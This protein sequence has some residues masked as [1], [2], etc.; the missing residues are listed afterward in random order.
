M[1]PDWP[2]AHGA[3]LFP[4]F[5][6][7]CSSDFIVD[8]L[9]GFEPSGDGEHDLLRIRKTDTNT[10][11]LARQMARHAGVAAK[12]VGYCGLKDRHAVTSQW[13]SVRRP[14]GK[15]TDWEAFQ[16]D[17]VELISAALHSR[18]LRPGSHA[19]NRFRIALRADSEIDGDAI[20]QRLNRIKADGV[21]NYFGEQRF[22]RDAGN[23]EIAKRLFSGARL[24][25]EQ[26]SIALSSARSFLFNEILAARVSD[27]TWNRILPGER[28]NLAG[29]G[30]VFSVEL[31][32]SE[33]QDRCERLDIHPTATLWG[34]G[35]PLSSGDVADLERRSI[36]AHAELADGLEKARV[37]PSSR[38]TRMHAAGLDWAVEQD[39]LWLEFELAPGGFATALLREIANV[40]DAAIQRS[41]SST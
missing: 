13:F 4:A 21:P 33:L 2:R 30:S 26:R 15:G 9:L 32:D 1:L 7:R 24:K 3:A 20:G 8:E 35:A 6:R 27:A 25:R 39:A 18:K 41:S 37:D 11:W 17:G 29:S 5:I 12:D 34:D 14:T 40:T 38:A 36:A 10:Q 28:A 31:V 19:A 16:L 23:L 22:G